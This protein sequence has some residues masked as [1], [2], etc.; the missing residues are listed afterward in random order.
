MVTA[1]SINTFVTFTRSP[2]EHGLSDLH[3][4]VR[5]SVVR[6]EPEKVLKVEFRY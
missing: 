1:A 3:K 4:D 6:N 5:L 2:C